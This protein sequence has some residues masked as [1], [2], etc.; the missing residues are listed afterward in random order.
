[1][2]L[3]A[4]SKHTGAGRRGAAEQISRGLTRIGSEGVGLLLTRGVGAEKP[5]AGADDCAG[6]PGWFPPNI[7]DGGAGQPTCLAPPSALEAPKLGFLI[8]RP[9]R[10]WLPA[11][12]ES[13][14]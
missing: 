2:S 10:E 11:A 1:M 12:N 13:R 5:K 6:V 4:K 8:T 3:S 14:R 7:L 9:E